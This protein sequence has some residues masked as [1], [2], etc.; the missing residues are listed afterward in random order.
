MTIMAVGII[1]G[2]NYMNYFNVELPWINIHEFLL[3]TGSI[4]VPKDFCLYL[5]ENVNKLIHYDQARVYF[6]NDNGKVYD[7]VLYGADR[8]WIEAYL[9]YYSK[10]EGGRYSIGREGQR[11][12]S[13]VV[14]HTFDW[15]NPENKNNEFIMD[16]IKPHC[17]RHSLSILFHDASDLTKT[18]ITFDRTSS[19][20]YTQKEIL[21][22]N[23][24]Q[25]H[26]DNLHKN[27]HVLQKRDRSNLAAKESKELLTQR[28]SEIVH[29]ICE[30][31][32]PASISQKLCLSTSTV[33]KH[34]AN[35]YAKMNITNR[36]E[37]ILTML[38][39]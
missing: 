14:N 37:L 8:N 38:N 16:Y 39:K 31:V 17:L 5:T 36:Q 23:I 33:Y 9:Q 34:I 7:T 3:K 4:R 6:I 30:G 22:F 10:I 26:S 32:T 27:L 15:S 19:S 25:S 18:I 28:E 24:I 13:N 2:G 20:E 11:S 35:I 29:L 12:K 21:I 1:C